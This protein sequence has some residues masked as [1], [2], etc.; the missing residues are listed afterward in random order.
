MTDASDPRA[1]LKELQQR[2]K[3]RFGQHF[4]ARPT[5]VHRMIRIA[6]VSEGDK[7]V[8]IGPGLGILT[9]ALLQTGCDL[10]AIEIDD[11]LYAHIERTYPGVR[12][13][14]VDALKADWDDIAPGPGHKLVANLPYNVGTHLVMDCARMPERFSSITVMLQKEVIDRMAAG[15]GTKAYGAL[16]VQLQVRGD[17]RHAFDVPPGAFIPPPKVHSAIVHVDLYDR[18]NVG[19]LSPAFF[20]KVV[21][22]AFGQRRKTVR[23]ALTPLFGRDV[24]VAALTDA[25]IRP[26]L[27]AEKLEV[28]G[29][30]ALANALHRSRIR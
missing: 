1:V 26:D 14:H 24:A 27:R 3:K 18:P 4:L 9:H 10:T 17:V 19:D 11:D 20:D 2:A 21:T 8:E 29:F 7:V 13:V 25:G 5:V 28:A 22:A 12:V 16:S 15:P 23:N 30:L 6:R